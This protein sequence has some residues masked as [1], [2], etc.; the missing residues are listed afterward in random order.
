[1]MINFLLQKIEEFEGVCIL[2]TNLKSAIDKAFVRRLSYRVEFPFP[3][4]K[5]RAAIWESIIPDEMPKGEE[6]DY[7]YLAK[8][9]KMSDGHI[10]NCLLRASFFALDE[11]SKVTMFHLDKSAQKECSEIGALWDINM[12]SPKPFVVPLR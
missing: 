12:E 11:N 1:M 3:D 6:F 8:K 9:Y 7:E 10:K 5:A 4:E 2:T